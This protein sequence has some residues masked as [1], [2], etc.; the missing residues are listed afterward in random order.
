MVKNTRLENEANKIEINQYKPTETTIKTRLNQ[1]F[2]AKREKGKF[3]AERRQ[4]TIWVLAHSLGAGPNHAIKRNSPVV[5][6]YHKAR[7][8]K[9]K[10]KKEQKVRRNVSRSGSEKNLVNF[11]EKYVWYG[12]HRAKTSKNVMAE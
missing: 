12:A 1:K 6:E 9:R 7:K 11:P 4:P 5:L 2:L 10:Q 8:E 3:E